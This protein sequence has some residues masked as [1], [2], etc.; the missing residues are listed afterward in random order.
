MTFSLA[1]LIWEEDELV[2]S[3]FVVIVE[4][5]LKLVGMPFGPVIQFGR[6]GRAVLSGLN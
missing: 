6:S 1:L 2:A 5:V 4:K 3:S